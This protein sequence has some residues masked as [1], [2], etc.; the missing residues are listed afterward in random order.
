MS[1]YFTKHDLLYCCEHDQE[2]GYNQGVT[3]EWVDTLPD[4]IKI[5]ISLHLFH[6]YKQGEPCEQHSRCMINLPE[7]KYAFVDVPTDFYLGLASVE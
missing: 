5:P 1:S 4:D 3:R 2:W 6:N 7:G